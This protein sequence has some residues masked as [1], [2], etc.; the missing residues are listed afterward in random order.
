MEEV[1]EEVLAQTLCSLKSFVQSK[2]QVGSENV[3]KVVQPSQP[4]RI[5][6]H[7]N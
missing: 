3:M 1:E 5:L 4:L 6:L 2:N 7:S